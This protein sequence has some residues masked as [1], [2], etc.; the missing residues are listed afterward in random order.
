MS[1]G[2]RANAWNCIPE[3]Q[4]EIELL[5]KINA[6]RA[7]KRFRVPVVL[8]GA[9]MQTVSEAM[10]GVTRIMAGVLYGAFLPK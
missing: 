10:T 7:K 5:E 3:T 8:T 2:F 9:E 4:L 6:L 1:S